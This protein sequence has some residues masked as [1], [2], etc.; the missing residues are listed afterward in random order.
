MAMAAVRSLHGGAALIVATLPVASFACWG[1][2]AMGG[3]PVQ[4]PSTGRCS[5]AE[6]SDQSVSRKAS[7]PREGERDKDDEALRLSFEFLAPFGWSSAL[8][9]ELAGGIRMEMEFQC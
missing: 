6:A 4:A 3:Q 1:P 7:R 9:G 2:R 8:F 5:S